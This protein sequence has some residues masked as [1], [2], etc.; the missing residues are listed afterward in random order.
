MT[1]AAN[2]AVKIERFGQGWQVDRSRP[3]IFHRDYW[4]LRYILEG[5]RDFVRGHE[6]ELRLGTALDFGAEWSPYQEIFHAHGLKLIRADVIDRGS[7]VLKIDESGRVPLGDGELAGVLSTQVLE[8]VADVQ[9]YLREAYRLLRPGGLLFLSTHG[10]FILHGQPYDF[11]RW[12]T[13]GLKYELE[14]AGFVVDSVTPRLGVLAMSTHLRSILFGGLTRKI[15]LTGWLR[16]LIYFL[17][18]LRMGIEEAITPA[19]VMDSHPEL[20]LA[21]ARKQKAPG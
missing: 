12:T 21:V 15:P 5:V 11:R 19:S 3:H 2:A 7:D 6:N 17:M 1:M 8:H 13:T 9:S 4:A 18:N 20:L 16:P 14:Q 10:A